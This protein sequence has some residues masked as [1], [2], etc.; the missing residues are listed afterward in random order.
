MDHVCWEED[1]WLWWNHH[2]VPWK[3]QTNKT[4]VRERVG[5]V[6]F[7]RPRSLQ[8]LSFTAQMVHEKQGQINEVIPNTMQALCQ[9]WLV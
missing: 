2:Y 4:K 1:M 3:Y 8:V 9:Y 5:K 7:L 6:E